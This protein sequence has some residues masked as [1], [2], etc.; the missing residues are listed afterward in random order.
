MSSGTSTGRWAAAAAAAVILAAALAVRLWHLGA[1]PTFFFHDECDNTVNAI[2]ILVGKGPGLYGMDWKPQP[3]LAVH[4]IALTIKA[5]GP[6][7]AAIR[8]PSAILSVV[9]LI[10]FLLV[11]R[12]VT[13]IVPALLASLLLA[14]NLG[15][16]HFSRTGWENV[17][18]SLYTLLAMEA[19]ARAEER[20]SRLWWGTAGIFA[21]VGAMAYFGGRAIIVFLTLYAAIKLVRARGRAWRQTLVG[22]AVMLV[23]FAV[24]IAP[25]VPSVA[26]DWDRFNTRTK[27]V[28]V[29]AD[30]PQNHTA[31]DVVR[32]VELN[33][34]RG[35]ATYFRGRV[36]NEPRYAPVNRPTLDWLTNGLLLIGLV[37][38]FRCLSATAL[39]WLAWLIPYV[40]TQVMASGAPN[41]ARGIAIIPILYL[42]VALGMR[43]LE[44]LVRRRRGL[45]WAVRVALAILV[46]VAAMRETRD[47]FAWA[48][49]PQ[50]AM[51]LHPAVELEDFDAWW[52]LQ[53]QWIRG[54][55]GFFNVDMWLE[56][57]AK[58]TTQAPRPPSTGTVYRGS[59]T[60]QPYAIDLGTITLHG[61]TLAV[62]VFS[63]PGSQG[64]YDYLEVTDASGKTQRVEAEDPRYTTGDKP[65]PYQIADNRWWLQEYDSFS[66]HEALLT[67]ENETPPPLTTRLSLP[68]GTYQVRVGSFTGD[69]RNGP[70][71]LQID[72]HEEG[73]PTP[74]H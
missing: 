21:A 10:P 37:A 15:Y 45:V 44:D 26:R 31:G 23:S 66:G 8:L 7:V 39:W 28:F 67:L 1:I 51:H 38:S 36:N 11:A 65:L 74:A 34:W 57:K 53:N 63:V 19:V 24:V 14:F 47:Y 68:P 32:A 33:A 18:V 27:A 62:T 43:T 30:L 60:A 12:R 25:L 41:L 55:R 20:G 6:S 52:E 69:S 56:R 48:T 59:I 13:G 46:I 16:I 2:Q 49:S 35:I 70:F 73:A 54:N 5:L 9:A 42:F 40:M 17:Q 58:Q 3:A 50:L 61:G 4:Q 22:T 29:T 72:L 71:A 64:A